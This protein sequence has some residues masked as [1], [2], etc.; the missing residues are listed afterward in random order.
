MIEE[1][2]LVTLCIFGTSFCIGSFAV[3]AGLVVGFITTFGMHEI[4]RRKK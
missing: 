3:I 1:T 4:E 2:V